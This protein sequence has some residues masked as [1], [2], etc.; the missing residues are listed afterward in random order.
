MEERHDV[1]LFGGSD[2]AIRASVCTQIE[3]HDWAREAAAGRLAPIQR[4]E[5]TGLLLVNQQEVIH[6]PGCWL[7]RILPL[8]FTQLFSLPLESSQNPCPILVGVL[9]GNALSEC[10][11]IGNR[12]DTR[13]DQSI[14]RCFEPFLRWE[15]LVASFAN[16]R[17]FRLYSLPPLEGEKDRTDDYLTAAAS[18]HRVLESLAQ[19]ILTLPELIDTSPRKWT[20]TVK[21]IR[22]ST[23]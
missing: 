21:T 11:H 23:I 16:R 15:F 9:V 13:L 6:F 7:R 4:L 19:H 2:F 12:R 14:I 1:G 22:D 20:L 8:V 5:K 17:P 10:L 18:G 3:G